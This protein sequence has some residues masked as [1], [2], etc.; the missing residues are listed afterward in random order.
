MK[1]MTLKLTVEELRLLVTLAS[2]QLFRKEFIEWKMPGHGSNS[3]EMNLGKALVGRLRLMVDEG[4]PKRTPPTRGTGWRPE[5]GSHNAPPRL[6]GRRAEANP[7]E[8]SA[9]RRY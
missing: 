7:T 4:S 8:E 3:G 6:R 1:R 9:A 2:D 5:Q